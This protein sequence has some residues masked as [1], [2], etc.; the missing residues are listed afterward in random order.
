MALPHGIML[1]SF[2][3]PFAAL[4]SHI[5]ARQFLALPSFPLAA[6]E[7]ARGTCRFELPPKRAGA[8]AKGC[9]CAGHAELGLVAPVLRRRAGRDGLPACDLSSL[10]CAI[11][12]ESKASHMLEMSSF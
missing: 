6:F 7:P 8:A 4:C 12:R 2:E 5:A 10:V 11:G 3:S 1:L 9:G